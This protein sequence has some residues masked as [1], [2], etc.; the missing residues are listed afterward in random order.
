MVSFTFPNKIEERNSR[1]KHYVVLS[2]IRLTYYIFNQAIM[3]LLKIITLNKV[4]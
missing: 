4:C 2:Y 1:T 3:M